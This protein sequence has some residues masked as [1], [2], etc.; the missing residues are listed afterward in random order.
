MKVLYK[1]FTDNAGITILP[2]GDWFDLSVA[3]DF[4][5][6][7]GKVNYVPLGVAMK[8]P[9]GMEAIMA[10]RSSTPKKYGIYMPISIGIIDNSYH[11]NED[12]WCYIA[13][14]LNGEDVNLQAGT[15]ICQFRIQLSQRATVL[16][17]IRWIFDS[18][19]TFKHVDNL[20]NDNRGGMGSTG[21]K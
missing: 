21:N 17:R 14:T 2:Q 13:S 16:D 18:K 9:H 11:G 1:T 6:L 3:R 12:E 8:L 15:R 20:S 7:K 5:V 10:S 4:T 19:I